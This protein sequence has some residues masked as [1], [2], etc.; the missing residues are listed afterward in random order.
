MTYTNAQCLAESDGFHTHT[1][2][3][4]T[5]RVVEHLHTWIEEHLDRHPDS[6]R[7]YLKQGLGWSEEPYRGTAAQAWAQ[8][9]DEPMPI[10]ECEVAA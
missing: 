2:Q 7:V 10:V 8:I 4:G 5:T 3:S 1:Y 6:S 9:S